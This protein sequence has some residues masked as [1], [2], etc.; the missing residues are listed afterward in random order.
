[1]HLLGINSILWPDS[2]TWLKEPDNLTS[3]TIKTKSVFMKYPLVYLDLWVLIPFHNCNKFKEKKLKKWPFKLIFITFLFPN[4]VQIIV[5]D[6][7][8]KISN[9]KLF[10]SLKALN[11]QQLCHQHIVDRS[12][13]EPTDGC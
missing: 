2:C 10:Y 3:K 6:K 9:E 1:M 7:F 4:C 12:P 13:M 8:H 11:K 5:Q